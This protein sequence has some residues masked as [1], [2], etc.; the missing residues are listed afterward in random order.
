MWN[1]KK[2]RNQ[3]ATFI[4]AS[5][6]ENWEELGKYIADRDYNGDLNQVKEIDKYQEWGKM[7]LEVAELIA[8]NGNQK[9]GKE[10]YQI[11][12]Q[13]HADE[14]GKHA[15]VE[16]NTINLLDG[17]KMNYDHDELLKIY[18]YAD[19]IYKTRGLTVNQAGLERVLNPDTGKYITQRKG[20]YTTTNQGSTVDAIVKKGRYSYVN[21]LNEQFEQVI[22]YAQNKS[23]TIKQLS[24]RGIVVDQW[25]DN[26][27]YIK[28][29]W[30]A[31]KFDVKSHGKLTQR[32]GTPSKSIRIKG[33]TREQVES[34]LAL[35]VEQRH[36]TA[37]KIKSRQGMYDKYGRVKL[38]STVTITKPSQTTSKSSTSTKITTPLT[39]PVVNKPASKSVE[40]I[41]TH[42][43]IETFEQAQEAIRKAFTGE[44]WRK[45]AMDYLSVDS[46]GSY[47]SAEAIHKTKVYI[48]KL[49]RMRGMGRF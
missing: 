11:A 31:L 17:K 39:L 16:I 24:K 28:C 29:H 42:K 12:V 25:A 41:N 33:Y 49:Q 19:K 22:A 8:G 10:E 26:R 2:P 23:D 18:G 14:R 48:F 38:K 5:S 45:K 1:K 7:S 44:K 46:N 4:L 35:P 30:E 20:G 43:K 9:K 36:L 34:E 37:D 32:K 21:D 27:K 40:E 6:D 3:A 47:N 13:T 15:H